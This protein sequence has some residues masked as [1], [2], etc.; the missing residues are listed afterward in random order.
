MLAKESTKELT[1]E[2]TKNTTNE[3][4]KDWRHGAPL[5]Q[6]CLEELSGRF[7]LPDEMVHENRA[8]EVEQLLREI[9]ALKEDKLAAYAAKMSSRQVEN[10][11]FAMLADPS[12]K[13]K[14]RLA[15][16]LSLRMTRRIIV[17]I[18][19]FY[20]YYYEDENISYLVKPAVSYIRS[21]GLNIPQG[22]MLEL[23]ALHGEEHP[24]H[25]V[26][27][28]AV[29]SCE[30]GASLV[31]YFENN[32]ISPDS[33]LAAAV[34]QRTLAYGDA[35]VFA[36]NEEWL[37]RLINNDMVGNEVLENYIAAVDEREYSLT[38]N[39]LII[40]KMGR[41]VNPEDW[42][43]FSEIHKR[44]FLRWCL[45]RELEDY[46]QYSRNKLDFFS[47]Y[48]PWLKNIEIIQGA[49]ASELLSMDF[50]E[51]VIMDA[52]KGADYSFL[53]KKSAFVRIRQEEL[54][55]T[56]SRMLI[57]A[58]EYILEDAQEEV[59]RLS[60][61]QIGKLFAREMLNILLNI[62]PDAR[63]AKSILASKRNLR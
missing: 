30:G 33:P 21:S 38:V 27:A 20:T 3:L 40:E 4:S 7:S 60:F 43:D 42:P 36:I 19:S 23:I 55:D 49:D 17:L 8:P 56:D 63:Y 44:K 16:L 32:A 53:C 29:M 57:E 59:I 41:P 58:R 22:K 48:L 62:I 54:F 47:G 51:F 13:Q 24:I 61:H 31:D 9:S 35:S 1:K 34:A 2:P 25:A 28:L 14:E 45:L 37:L 10:F 52:Q 5:F 12:V 26:N 6:K 18:W 46:F 50:G 39:E 11:I 15:K